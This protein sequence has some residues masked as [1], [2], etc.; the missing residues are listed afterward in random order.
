MSLLL[1]LYQSILERFEHFGLFWQIFRNWQKPFT[2]NE[3]VYFFP[4]FPVKQ[5]TV[6][7]IL[8]VVCMQENRFSGANLKAKI[9]HLRL[10][11]PSLP[12]IITNLH[13]LH[14]MTRWLCVQS[15]WPTATP[16]AH[17]TNMDAKYTL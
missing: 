12:R 11:I 5:D 9:A 17:Q 14:M 8:D 2:G 7:Q 1:H 13:G 10:S 6:K 4:V 3:N 16:L 15:S